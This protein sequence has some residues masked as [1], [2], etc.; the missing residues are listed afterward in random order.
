MLALVANL[1]ARN[2]HEQFHIIVAALTRI[3][4]TLAANP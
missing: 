1:G 3:Y 4:L 2:Q